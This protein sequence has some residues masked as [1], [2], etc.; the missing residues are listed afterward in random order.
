MRSRLSPSLAL[1]AVVLPVFALPTTASG[2]AGIPDRPAAADT[3]AAVLT[4]SDGDSLLVLDSLRRTGDRLEVRTNSVGRAR[5][6]IGADLTSDASVSRARVRVWPEGSERPQVDVVLSFEDGILRVGSP[7]AEEPEERRVPERTLIYVP[8]SAAFLEQ[9]VRRARALRP[10]AGADS[11]AFTLWSPYRGGRSLEAVAGFLR[12]DTV[13]LS[14][15]DATYTLAV[16][17]A[18]NL[19]GG[20]LEPFGHTISRRR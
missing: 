19:L 7:G 14:F 18:G 6:V 20:R 17:S 16:D 4:I 11:V 13:T 3:G 12:A 10:G 2:Q 5:F 15:D 1:T 9:A 8:P